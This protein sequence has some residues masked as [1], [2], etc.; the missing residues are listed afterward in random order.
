[1][2]VARCTTEGIVTEDMDTDAEVM[3]TDMDARD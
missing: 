2:G 3:D 1:M